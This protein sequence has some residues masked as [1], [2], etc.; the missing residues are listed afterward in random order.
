MNA[1]L[2]G[3]H[4]RWE[5]KLRIASLAETV[6]CYYR[7]ADGDCYRHT[8]WSRVLDRCISRMRQLRRLEAR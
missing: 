1:S 8:K 2:Q 7:G 4:D 6:H 3:Q 5:R